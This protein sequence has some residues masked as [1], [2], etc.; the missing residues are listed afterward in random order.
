MSG[1]G[2]LTMWRS[3][4]ASNCPNR[5][6]STPSRLTG[7]SNMS[8]WHHARSG[9]AWEFYQKPGASQ[10]TNIRLNELIRAQI[11]DGRTVEI[12][13]AH[14]PDAEWNGFKVCGAEGLEAGLIADFHLPWNMRG[15]LL[16]V[17]PGETAAMK[18]PSRPKQAD[19][20]GKILEIVRRRPGMTELEIAKKIYGPSALQPQVNPHCRRLLES[21][22]VERRGSG[23]VGDPF[24]Y[25]PV[26]DVDDRN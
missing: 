15:A 19:I 20:K 7:S 24:I 13:L 17:Q 25:Y 10:R 2:R 16:G 23:G 5:R 6:A 26:R 22:L 11:G 8:V 14:P 18:F 21:G 12:L 4:M 3:G 9:S 1:H